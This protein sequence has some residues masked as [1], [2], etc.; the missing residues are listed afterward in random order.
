MGEGKNNISF[1]CGVIKEGRESQQAGQINRR[2][3][4]N[5]RSIIR[6]ARWTQP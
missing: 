1:V 6:V 5:C 3:N 4:S 2:N